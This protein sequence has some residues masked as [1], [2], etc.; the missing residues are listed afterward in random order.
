MIINISNNNEI[1]ISYLKGKIDVSEIQNITGVKY[2]KK[3]VF[4]EMKNINNFKYIII[5]IAGLKDSE[6]DIVDSIVAIKSM[7]SIRVVILALG[8]QHGN[9]TLARLF[10]EGIY[11]FV[12]A[13][14]IDEQEK[15]LLECIEGEGKQYKDSVRFRKVDQESNIKNKVIIKKEY[16][17]LKQFVTI[18]IAGTQEHIGST[19]QALAITKFLNDL[20]LNVCYIQANGKNDIQTIDNLFEV[21]TKQDYI[22]YNGIDMY[23]KDKTI[24]AI[25]LGYDFYIYDFG[26]FNNI[27]DIDSYITKDVKILVSGTKAWEQQNLLDVFNRLKYLKDINFIFNFTAEEQKKHIMNNMGKLGAKTYFS[28]YIPDPFNSMENEKE[29]HKIFKDYIYEKSSKIEIVSDDKK[30]ILNLFNRRKSD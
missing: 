26:V 17:K 21:E 28:N 13:T 12:T 27:S 1:I 7:Y 2:L 4:Q 24:N 18:A 23:C 20:K 22:R 8:Y 10:N 25:E 14:T 30:N 6:N 29:Y 19:T 15:E 9:S 11:N 3:F 5:D 16:R